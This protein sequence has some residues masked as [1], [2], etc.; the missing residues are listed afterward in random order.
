MRKQA[1]WRLFM[2]GG[3]EQLWESFQKQPFDLVVADILLAGSMSGISLSNHIR[4]LDGDAGSVPILAITAFD[5]LARR[6]D[7][8]HLGVDD[9]VTKPILE[10]EL[11]ARIRNLLERSYMARDLRRRKE[12]AES[13]ASFSQVVIVELT[14][15]WR[16]KKP[17][18]ALC[19]LLGRDISSLQERPE[20]E[21]AHPAKLTEETRLR[22]RLENGETRSYSLEKAYILPDGSQRHV[23]FNC[24]AVFDERRRLQGYLVY[25]LDISD[26]KNAEAQALLAAK[27]F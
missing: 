26:R 7:L 11:I 9:Y 21:F 25:L 1:R 12:I 22:K 10:V 18:D 2:Q 3:G 13:A 17:S 6:I 5:D 27:V 8:Y 19:A 15:D 20:S 23:L 14:T 4:R 16:W 24:A